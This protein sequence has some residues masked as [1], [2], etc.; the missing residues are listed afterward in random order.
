M[1]NGLEIQSNGVK[2]WFKDDEP[3]R[4]DGPAMVWIN[5]SHWYYEGTYVK[6]ISSQEEFEE[7]LK[8]KAFV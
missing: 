6:G 4:L 5:A 3:H 8:Y 1:K 7:W 2:I